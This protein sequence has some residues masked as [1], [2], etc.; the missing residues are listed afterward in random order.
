MD[1]KYAGINSIIRYVVVGENELEE[2]K[3][4]NAASRGSVNEISKDS[5]L[6]Q[7]LMFC[8]EG[9]TVVVDAQEPYEVKII[10]IVN[11]VEKPVPVIRSFGDPILVGEF[12][13]ATTGNYANFQSDM[14]N[15]LVVGHAYGSKAQDVYKQGQEFFGWDDSKQGYFGAQQMLYAKNCTKEGFAVW[16]LTYSN[17]NN[18]T[19]KAANWIDFISS[20]FETVKEVWKNLDDRFFNDNEK[21]VTFAKQKNGQY[22][23]LGIFQ[24]TE[25]DQENRCKTFKRID[26]N[27]GC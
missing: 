23:Y 17:L 3:L 20:D 21:R 9:D 11:P 27:Y 19:N 1:L 6:G 22:L 7:A 26:L 24:A 15:G 25:W 5:I 14:Q 13:S 18:Y 2:I 8:Q 4:V 16:F 12:V 10:N